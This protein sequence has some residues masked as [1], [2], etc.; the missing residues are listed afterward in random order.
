[1]RRPGTDPRAAWR[2]LQELAFKVVDAGRGAGLCLPTKVGWAAFGG[3]WHGSG[4]WVN[5]GKTLGWPTTRHLMGIMGTT[6]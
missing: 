6:G 1:M 4:W 2:T 5:G 3:C